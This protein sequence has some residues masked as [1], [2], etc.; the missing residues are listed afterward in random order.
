[1]LA[2]EQELHEKPRYNEVLALLSLSNMKEAEYLKESSYFHPNLRNLG[3]L[4]VRWIYIY[5]EETS[6]KE[7]EEDEASWEQP[8]TSEE[9]EKR[10]KKR[11]KAN[12][13]IIY[14]KKYHCYYKR[15]KETNERF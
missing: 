8:E 15:K 10:K 5:T 7:E 14:K 2:L 1:M 11:T 12:K 9:E 3:R 4:Q 13:T 6:I